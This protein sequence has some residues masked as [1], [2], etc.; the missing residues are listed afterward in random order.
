MSAIAGQFEKSKG[1]LNAL[2]ALG[3][4][5]AFVCLL[6]TLV[7]AGLMFALTSFITARFLMNGHS[8]VAAVLGFCGGLVAL[9][10]GLTGASA[11]GFILNAQMQQR[12]QPSISNALMTALVTLP[13]LIGVYLLLLAILLGLALALL[14]LLLLCKIPGLGPVLYTLVFPVGIFVM[15]VALYSAIYVTALTG[16]A[17]WN[18]NTLL[19]AVSLLVAIAQKRLLSVIVQTL[20][21]GLLVSI[22][23][24]IIFGAL[25]LGFSATSALS[26]P[27]LGSGA[28]G[29]GS[30]GMMGLMG[31]SASGYAAAAMFGGSL[32]TIAASVLPMLL[33]IAGYCR[34]FSVVAE[35]LKTGHI[36]DRIRDAQEK[37]R[38]SME[39]ARA[40]V[41]A[42][43]GAAAAPTPPAAAATSACPSCQQ[44][45][46]PDDVFCGHCGHK[47][48]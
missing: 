21:L 44:G 43:T 8:G 18:G 32:L 33:T 30:F 38:T 41:A 6:I 27:V 34:I 17:I 4:R 20:L 42:Q 40:Q 26:L 11:T 16:P 46:G 28:G 5:R 31:G 1:L 23:A 25:F 14:V 29:M 22:V 7:G 19:Q 47:L 12:E 15:G 39:N 10:I 36:E 48:K 2:D 45:V 13:R 3:N 24:G 35:G 9:L 37:A